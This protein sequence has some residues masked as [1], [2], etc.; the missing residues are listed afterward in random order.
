MP[1]IPR[2]REWPEGVLPDTVNDLV[3]LY[4]RGYQGAFREPECD[5]E[6]DSTMEWKTFADAAYDFNLVGSS[7]GGV[8]LPFRSILKFEPDAFKTAQK[9]G[10]CV[11]FGTRN[12]HD[13]PRAVEIDIANEP[14]CWVA[15]CA[16]EPEYKHR[17]HSGEGASCSRIAKWVTTDGGMLL[18]KDYSDS[19]GID[20]SEYNSDT[21]RWSSNG[22][23]GND[24]PTIEEA[25][26]HPVRYITRVQGPDEAAD[27]LANGYAMSVCS[28]Y[29][30]TKRR[31]D[32][33]IARPSGSWA[34]CMCVCAVDSAAS[35]IRKHRGRLFLILNS[36]GYHWISGP[37]RHN[38]PG[39]SFW[40]TERTMKGMIGANGTFAFGDTLGFPRKDLPNHLLI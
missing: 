32:E 15:L 34:H 26:K 1:N 37:K 16:T 36:W 2:F 29:G 39:G 12:A 8:F 14:E 20:L 30:F 7:A 22:R 5:E 24:A 19:F 9:R 3:G 38:Q 23:R 13:I 25:K 35:T 4:D 10:D 28:S 33:G 31:D 6:L 40:V 17:G 21:R 11:S 18:R 27:A